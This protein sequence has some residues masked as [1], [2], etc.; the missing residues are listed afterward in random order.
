M[1]LSGDRGSLQPRSIFV[2]LSLNM[3]KEKLLYMIR[4]YFYLVLL[5][6]CSPIELPFGNQSLND[7]SLTEVR[8]ELVQGPALPMAKLLSSSISNGLLKNGITAS[9]DPDI[10]SRFVLKGLARANWEDKKVPFVM[11]IY[12]T[13]YD[14]AGKIL[15]THTQGVRGA[16]W[17]WEY[18]DPKI[19]SAVGEGAAKSI[20]VLLAN[21]DKPIQNVLFDEGVL[22][23]GVTGAPGDGNVALREAIVSGLRSSNVKIVEDTRQASLTLTG[24][25]SLKPKGHALEEVQ[26]TWSVHTLD[27]FEVGRAT[28]VNDIPK[29]KLDELW[30][31]EASKIAD[32]ALIGIK[33]IIGFENP[34]TNQPKKVLVAQPKLTPDLEQIPNNTAPPLQ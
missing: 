13:L 3:N 19:I 8:V 11:L 20:A 17:K 15:G 32:A 31:D 14:R 2:A 34:S 6:A 33:R 29:G 23:R 24:L 26:V 9:V 25:V 1:T 22:I 30:A 10:A 5:G 16:R 27:G 18:G 28:Q 12:W 4:L 21:E 7:S